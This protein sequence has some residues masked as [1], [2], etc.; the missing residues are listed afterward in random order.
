MIS[1][2]Y[3][4][5]GEPKRHLLPC[6][7]AEVVLQVYVNATIRAGLDRSCKVSDYTSKKNGTEEQK[8]NRA[9]KRMDPN[10]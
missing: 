5:I 7:S 9:A 1:Q 2:T 3:D 4:S 10:S 8:I 6:H